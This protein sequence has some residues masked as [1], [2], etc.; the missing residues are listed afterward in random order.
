MIFGYIVLLVAFALSIVSAYYSVL[1]L[2]SIFA[3]AAIPVII[4][5]A[6]LE[7]GK[8]TA[9]LW[10]HKNWHRSPMQYK[11]YLVPAMIFLMLLTSMGV[12]GFLSK[13]HSDNSL[14]SGDVQAKI[15]IYDEKIKVSQENIDA[16]R[17][18]LKQLDEAVDQVMGRS[19]SETGADKAVA[20]RKSQAKER[21]RLFA[22]ITA[23]QKKITGLR[24]E[25]A[26]IAAEVR[27][28]EAEVGPIKYIAKFIYGDNPDTNILEKAVTWVIILIVSVFDPLAIVLILAGQRQLEWAREDRRALAEAALDKPKYEPDDGPVTDDQIE[29]IKET[30]A[31]TKSINDFVPQPQEYIPDPDLEPFDFDKHPYL[32]AEKP[33]FPDH[34]YIEPVPPQVYRPKASEPNIGPCRQC[35]TPLLLAPGIGPFCPNKECNVS[36]APFLDQEPIEITYTP[37]KPVVVIVEE[38]SVPVETI[39]TT[40]EESVPVETT[41]TTE[42]ELEVARPVALARPPTSVFAAKPPPV[43]APETVQLPAKATVSVPEA[44]NPKAKA[45]VP[46]QADN[47]SNSS[48]EVNAQFGTSFPATPNKGDLFLRVDY[49]PTRLFRHNGIKWMEA[50]KSLT[51]TYSYNEEYIAYL[52]EQIASGTYD[53]EDLSDSEKFQIEEFL[54]KNDK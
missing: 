25:R 5:G 43:I 30:V 36:D 20:V 31:K 23:E 8:V 32:L 7:V 6:S 44:I 47:D 16:N 13:A 42:E 37:P 54:K 14:V 1:G 38:E 45:V 21:T 51:D 33:T 22:E 19:T 29:Q 10:L 26:P 9:A 27:K 3:A 12:F 2:V 40:E 4:M 34:P 15:A 49:L 46:L 28:V 24:E 17:K 18:A 50:D 53:P 39:P 52:V 35:G 11:L 48:I 41:P